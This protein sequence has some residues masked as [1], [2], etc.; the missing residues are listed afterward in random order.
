MRSLAKIRDGRAVL[1]STSQLQF[2]FIGQALRLP[3]V[4]GEIV[5]PGAEVD[6]GTRCPPPVDRTC[7]PA[8]IGIATSSEKRVHP[9][10]RDH[11]LEQ[12]ARELLRANGA[13]R[14]SN[15][16]RV[17]W[18]PRLKSCAGRADYRE[19]VISLNPELLE[20]RNRNKKSI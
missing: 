16:I 4:A 3:T 1:E 10:Q 15:N 7:P 11:A 20:L 12:Q 2:Q 13:G 5:D 14:I 17:E 18:N 6:V 19:K 8:T 9:R